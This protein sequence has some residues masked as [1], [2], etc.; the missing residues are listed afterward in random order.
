MAAS[1]FRHTLR[2][3]RH[4]NY[5]IFF[6]G[7]S[8]SLIGTWTQQVAMLWLVY[9]LSGSAFLLG[10]TAF[11]AQIPI[12]LFAP[13][14]GLCSDLFDRRKMMMAT[15]IAA[16]V[17]GIGMAVVAYLDAT[18]PAQVI[19]MAW[20]LGMI[21]ALETPAR[22]SFTTELVPDRADLPSAIAINAMMQNGGRMI[23]PTVAGILLAQTSEAFCFLLNSL[24]KVAGVAALAGLRIT[25][26]MVAKRT[27]NIWHELREGAAYGWGL[28][29]IRW[30]LGTVALVSFTVSPYQA[31]APIYAAEIFHGGAETL[32]FLMGSAGIGAVCGLVYLASRREVRGLTRWTAIGITT[33]GVSVMIF[34]YS[35][36]LPLSLLMMA[37]V[38]FGIIITAMT[39]ST[40]IQ[41]VVE[42]R[43]RGRLMS[44]FTMAFLGVVPLGSLVAGSVAQTIGPAP[45]LFAG[46]LICVCGAAALWSRM[47]ILRSDMRGIYDRLEIEPRDVGPGSAGR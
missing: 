7:Q 9:R 18:S 2:A 1:G 23:G 13:F 6:A 41:T 38:G 5:R 32:G 26:R 3:L 15:Q 19:V 25:P 47:G 42:D 4:T 37:G 40:I 29:P 30:L 10:L 44:F 34:S 12:L 31:L 46:G 36:M 16:L 43:M 21:L 20:L 17:Q 33:A 39:T 22:Q 28:R 14:G 8:L 35:R 45:T 24:S 11:A 27:G